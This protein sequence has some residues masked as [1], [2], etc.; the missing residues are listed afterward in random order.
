MKIAVAGLG[1][2]GL[3]NAVLLAQNHTVKAVD[4]D[5]NCVTMVNARKY[6]I[7]D[8]ELEEFLAEKE[9]DLTATTSAEDACH[10]AD[11]V[12]VA[13]PTSYGPVSSYFDTRFIEQ[14]IG[15]VLA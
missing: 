9:L 2:V 7:A 8:A 1:C 12:I 13:T 3:S 4:I 5:E 14:V 15:Y 6:P 10:E 11:F